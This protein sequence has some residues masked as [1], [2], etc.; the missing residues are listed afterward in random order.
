MK[1]EPKK[2]AAADRPVSVRIKRCS[3]PALVVKRNI[4]TENIVAVTHKKT[5]VFLKKINKTVNIWKSLSLKIYFVKIQFLYF[6][7]DPHACEKKPIL[8]GHQQA[9]AKQE[10]VI[11]VQFALLSES[12]QNFIILRF[13][14]MY[15]VK[16]SWLYTG[17]W[18]FTY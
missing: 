15:G 4:V 17:S 14:P 9:H 18:I 8:T 5:V 16:L 2:P 10:K 6:F 12:V 3:K 1:D 11:I 7:K 13:L